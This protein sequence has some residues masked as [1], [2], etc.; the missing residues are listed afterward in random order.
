MPAR[1]INYFA[2][3]G[4]IGTARPSILQ[5]A[6]GYILRDPKFEWDNFLEDIL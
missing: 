6:V 1:W 3:N 5:G 2:N 4:K